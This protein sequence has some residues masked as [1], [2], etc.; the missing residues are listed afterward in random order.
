MIHFFL[1][2]LVMCLS[3]L[4]TGLLCRYA[5]KRRLLDIPNSRSSHQDPTPRGG[6]LAIVFCFLGGLLYLY[7]A[8]DIH[9]SAFNAL[10]NGGLLVAA[11][12]CWDDHRHIPARWRL[13]VHFVAAAWALFIIGG[14]PDLLVGRFVWSPCWLGYGVGI[15]SLV[16]LLNLYNFMDGI[17]GIAGV[18]A[19][20]VAIGAALIMYLNGNSRDAF[21]LVILAAACL[22]FLFLNWPPAKI[23]MGDV[24]SGFLGF[25]LGVFALDTAG[26]D[27][28]SLW[29][30][31]ILLAVFFVDAT[32][33]LLRRI[34]RGDR[35][36]E[37]HRSHAYQYLSLKLQKKNVL[38]GMSPVMARARG[39]R[40]VILCVAGINFFWLFP[41]A[42]VVSLRPK[43]GVYLA[44][45]AIVPLV[46]IAIKLGA[47][48]KSV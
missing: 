3:F 31:V 7:F 43:S 37:A 38:K 27:A 36:Y 2:G 48:K 19:I 24:G 8:G 13:L 30:W 29:C 5:K 23:F 44:C 16:W 10:F 15:V 20:S 33:T 9:K 17:D 40:F 14:F 28:L 21:P 4:L 26:S 47:G 6:G 22:G 25:V 12:G 32:C 35:F 42:G 45:I 39:H 34:L 18:E 11:I 46:V 1:F 41:L